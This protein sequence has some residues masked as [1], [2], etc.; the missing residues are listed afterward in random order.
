[1]LWW[2]SGSRVIR[3]NE[4]RKFYDSTAH[5]YDKRHDNPTT[6][7]VRSVEEKLIKKY[8][9]GYVLDVGCGTGHHI[10]MLKNATGVDFSLSMVKEARRKTENKIYHANAEELPFDNSSFNSIICLNVLNL[11]D[12]EKAV[13]EMH[14]VLKPGG[15]AVVSVTSV[16]D[17]YDKPL[18][19]K[20]RDAKPVAKNVRIEGF[21]LRMHLFGRKDF[22][23]L[24]RRNGFRKIGFHS[25][26]TM[27]KPYWGWYR[28]F[29]LLEKIKLKADYV[30]PHRAGR[31]YI[32]IFRKR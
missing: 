28:N 10:G 3:V 21:R 20:A 23:G 24:F 31:I 8:A 14:R 9:R 4:I 32:G 22:I 12:S 30:V 13:G 11:C 7:Y 29:T 17:R 15:N 25:L 6:R 1:M 19:A 5:S 16:W 27:Q 18:W 2:I 26:F